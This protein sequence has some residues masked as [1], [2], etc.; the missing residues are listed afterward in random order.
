MGILSNWFGSGSSGSRGGRGRNLEERLKALEKR[1]S[2][3]RP[4]Q[5]GMPLNRAGDLCL[6]ADDKDRALDYYGRAID[7]FLEEG[8]P[9][10]A[11]GV[12]NKIIRIHP[13]AIRTLCTLTWLDLASRHTATALIHLR[14]YVGAA[15]RGGVEDLARKHILKMARVVSDEE[16][17]GGAADALDLL[18]FGGDAGEVRNGP[19]PDAEPSTDPGELT[20]VCLQGA[21]YSNG[22]G[23]PGI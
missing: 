1:S 4:G 20:R 17:L 14:D 19:A 8:Q 15:K 5:Q 7:V 12:A 6:D 10:A 23:P 2:E 3:A 22:K 16:F 9:D 21:L 13:E 11:R 18:G